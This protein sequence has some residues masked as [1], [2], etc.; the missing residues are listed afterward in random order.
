MK[1]GRQTGETNPLREDFQ[2][3]RKKIANAKQPCMEGIE[4]PPGGEVRVEGPRPS[5][6]AKHLYCETSVCGKPI[7]DAGFGQQVAGASRVTLEF[8]PELRHVDP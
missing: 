7:A 1:E 5:T 2:A 4:T 6:P 3:A 8:S